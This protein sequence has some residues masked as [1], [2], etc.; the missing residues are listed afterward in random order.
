MHITLVSPFDPTPRASED[1]KAHVGGVERVFAN[2]SSHLDRRGHEVRVVCSTDGNESEGGL[3]GIEFVREQ[4]AGTLFRAPLVNLA[5]RIEPD[6]DVVHV[7]ATYPFTTPTV[8]RRAGKLDVPAVLDFHFE[9]HP[10]SI[11][12]QLAAS[13]YRRLAPR[14]YRRADAVLVNSRE[15]ARTAPSLDTIPEER[16]R[17]LPN[18]IEPDRFTPEGPERSGEY[19]LFVG[20]LVP[21]KGLE[22]LLEAIGDS[23][24]RL[25]L[26]IAGDGPRRQALEERAAQLDVDASFLGYV[27]GDQLPG[28]YRGARFTVLP[29]V[30]QQEAFG[31]CLLESMACGT[32]VVASDLPGVGQ[33]AREGGLVARPGDAGELRKQIQRALDPGMLPSGRSLADKIHERYAWS[34]VTDRLLD[35][36]SQVSTPGAKSTLTPPSTTGG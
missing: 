30:N 2:L 36:Y 13:V 6:T 3:D 15:Y 5:K 10:D 12:G 8:L 14:A 28:L 33:V 18:G 27:P 23:E 31:I 29:S 17:E 21:Y 25:P 11:L 24:I 35:I 34:A 9:P 4:R 22:V 19:M 26:L 20:R 16:W 32:P 1:G 7:A